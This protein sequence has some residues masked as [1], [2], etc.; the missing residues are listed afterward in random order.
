[1]PFSRADFFAVFVE[2]NA[3]LWPTQVLACA[4]ALLCVYLFVRR[5]PITDRVILVV[6]AVMWAVN[7]IGYH[8]L[9]FSAINPAAYLFAAFFVVEAACLAVFAVH[10]TAANFVIRRDSRT[11][12][13]LLLIVFA[14]LLYPLWGM[15]AGHRYPAMP[16][17]GIAPCPTTIFTIGILLLGRWTV[18]RWL[19]PIPVLRSAIG[20]TAAF[21][22]GVPQDFGLFAAGMIAVVFALGSMRDLPIARHG[23][24]PGA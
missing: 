9:F 6:L 3:A 1:M 20:G 4:A 10:G 23:E 21:V 19:L 7:G 22:L 14:I 5:S 17:L 11:A 13:G 12:V 2:Y 8:G 24:E 16:M 15:I 18:V